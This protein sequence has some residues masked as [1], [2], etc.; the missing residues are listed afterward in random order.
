MSRGLISGAKLEQVI[1]LAKAKGAVPYRPGCPR[2][3][4]WFESVVRGFHR[5]VTATLKRIALKAALTDTLPDVS[6]D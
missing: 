5:D 2:F 4:A 3:D 1:E 6:Y